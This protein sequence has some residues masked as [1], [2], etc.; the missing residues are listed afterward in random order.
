VLPM[1]VLA[2][3]GEVGG[4]SS[5]GGVR[6]LPA[7]WFGCAYRHACS[8]VETTTMARLLTEKGQHRAPASPLS[9]VRR[10]PPVPQPPAAMPH[11]APFP[12][13]A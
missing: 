7:R 8:D 9:P 2:G 3:C 6:G 11:L 4:R 1:M 10:N 12:P 5:C 13:P